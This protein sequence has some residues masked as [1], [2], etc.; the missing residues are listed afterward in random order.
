MSEFFVGLIIALLVVYFAL[1]TYA[2]EAL[3]S[4]IRFVM[5]MLGG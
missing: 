4:I 2:P 5:V 1:A 3:S